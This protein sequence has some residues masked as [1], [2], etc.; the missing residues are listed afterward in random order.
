MRVTVASFV[1]AF[2]ISKALAVNL[3]VPSHSAYVIPGTPSPNVS[4]VQFQST[5]SQLDAPKLSPVNS[6]VFD[7]WYWD[8]VA[9]DLSASVVLTVFTAEPSGLWTGIPITGSTTWF[10]AMFTFTN[11]TP[12]TVFLPADSLAVKTVGD[13]S[14]GSFSGIDVAWTGSSD[15]SKYV[16]SIDEPSAGIQGTFTL[17][18]VR[19]NA[20]HAGTR[21]NGCTVDR[22]RSSALF[23]IHQES[24][25][26]RSQP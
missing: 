26:L 3:R 1:A 9:D 8:A 4:T 5:G 23:G 7:W 18:S 16:M 19:F 21:L 12:W 20:C 25:I 24:S 2:G 13:G 6:T 22:S 15:M 11:G 14:S 17:A 10:G